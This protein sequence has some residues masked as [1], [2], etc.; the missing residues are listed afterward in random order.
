[1]AFIKTPVK[2]MPDLLPEDVALRE[3][4]F[5]MI[6]QAYSAY[7]FAQIETPSIEHIENLS[8]KQG[9]ENEK[10][11]FKILKRGEDFKNALE[12]GSG[13][14][15]DSGL[16]YDLTVPL[17]RY[18]AANQSKLPAPFKAM[19]IGNV[20]RAD[21]PQKGRFRQFVQCDIDILGDDSILAEIE[22]IAATAD[23]LTKIFAQAGLSKFTVHI[24]D[25]RILRAA[26]AYAGFEECDFDRVLIILD[27]YDK[28]GLEGIKAELEKA[29]FVM[30]AIEKYTQFYKNAHK[31]VGCEEFCKYLADGYLAPDVA[32][33]IDTIIACVKEMADRGVTVMFDPTLVRGMSYY[34]GTIFECTIDGYDFS[35]AGG[36]RYDKMIGQYSGQQVCA[37]G[38]SIGFERIIT[39]LKDNKVAPATTAE[40]RAVLIEKGTPPQKMLEVM[41]AAKA[42]RADG[43]TVS[44]LPMKK[45]TKHQIDSLIEQGYSDVERVY[46]S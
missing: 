5:K 34:T 31:G 13:E 7:G 37:C 25:R 23:M 16:R 28:I 39:I 38:F 43:K 8:N 35:I 17:A 32:T 9:G 10:L 45:N 6:K 21:K 18:Y 44:I 29:G 46:R 20:W 19:Q 36:G 42:A 33:G 4:I 40:K 15:A 22:L 11:I 30:S 12:S 2:G 26:A 1:M 14:L 24:S 41:R 27:K 3:S